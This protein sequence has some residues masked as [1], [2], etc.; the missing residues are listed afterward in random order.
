[1]RTLLMEGNK[2][3]YYNLGSNLFF[4]EED[5]DCNFMIRGTESGETRQ[6]TSTAPYVSVTGGTVSA[7]ERL[8][9][10]VIQDL[11][12]E[13]ALL[14]DRYEEGGGWRGGSPGDLGRGIQYS[15]F[16]RLGSEQLEHYGE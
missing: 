16:H 3:S 2:E 6:S 9:I 11:P 15:G 4:D 1:M 5:P 10:R 7:D 12:E 14:A 13:A 8:R